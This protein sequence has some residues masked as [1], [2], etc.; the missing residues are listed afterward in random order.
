MSKPVTAEHIAEFVTNLQ[1]LVDAHHA[2]SG[3]TRFSGVIEADK[4]GRKYVRITKATAHK[5]EEG[6]VASVSGKHA[7]CFVE[8]STGNVFKVASWKTP[9]KHPRG[10][11]FGKTNTLGWGLPSVNRGH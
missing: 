9:A 2:K 1:E 5:D 10:S 3:Y 11:I 7:F 6:R 4:G 8:L